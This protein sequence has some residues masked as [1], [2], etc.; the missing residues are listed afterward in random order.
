MSPTKDG[1]QFFLLSSVIVLIVAVLFRWA[2]AVGP[3]S[4]ENKPPMF[5][6]YEAQRHW[7]EITTNLPITHWYRNGTNNDLLYWGLDYPPLTAYH[8]WILGKIYN[9]VSLG[10]FLWSICGLLRGRECIAAFLFTMALSYKQMELY[11][12]I[13]IFVY[14]FSRCVMTLAAALPSAVLLF[15][16]PG[17]KNLLYSLVLTSLGFFLFSFQVHE[18]GILLVAM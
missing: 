11:H 13:P 4:G 9:C 15:I 1:K 6:D 18:K 10:L 7:M 3:Y 17:I 8:M 16:R 5:G 14:L 12:A 2:V